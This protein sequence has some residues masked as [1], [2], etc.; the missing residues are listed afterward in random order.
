VANL[1]H[2]LTTAGEEACQSGAERAGAFDR[3]RAPAVR[4]LL[5]ECQRI[6]VAAA[7]SRDRCLENDRARDD[8]DHRE[9]V[10]IAMR[11]DTDD[12]VQLICKHPFPDLQP[13]RWGT[14]PVSVWGGNRGRQNCDGSRAHDADR[15]LIRPASGRQIDTGLST[16]TNH[17][18]D[19][20]TAGHSRIESQAEST[21]ANLTTA[22]D[23]T[24]PHTHSSGMSPEDARST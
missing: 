24:S 8:L 20:A 4:V 5:D 16:R 6:H 1:E 22:P 3:E 15:L 23:G 13:E 19:T 17:W 12:V 14:Q 2:P 7:V 11:I 18:K 9:R 10:R 21:G